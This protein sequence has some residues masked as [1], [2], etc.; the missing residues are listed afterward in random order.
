MLQLTNQM[1]EQ[2]VEKWDE[3]GFD[4]KS[5]SGDLAK[6]NLAILLEN[7]HNYLMEANPTVST[8]I[9]NFN[10]VLMPLVRRIF[11]HLIANDLVGVQPMT[12]PVGLAYAMRF[13]RADTGAE[14][15]FNTI[16]PTFTGTNAS[17]ASPYGQP[18][19]YNAADS[20]STYA[21]AA[22][23]VTTGTGVSTSAGE[24]MD[25]NYDG[26]NPGAY[27]N[28]PASSMARGKATVEQVMVSAK[29]RKMKV[30]YSLEAAQDLKNMH[31]VELEQELVNLLQYEVAAEI[32]REL[33][34]HIN[35]LAATYTTNYV[36]SAGDAG[37][38]TGEA[39][40]FR[41]LYTRMVRESAA[42]A[43]RTRR[44]AG[45]FIV[46]SDNV[47]TALDGLG[48][49]L[50]Q[51]IESGHMELN[52]GVAK[53]GSIGNR[54]NVYRDTFATTDY[55]TIGYKGP[56]AQNAGVIYCP[57]IPLMLSKT[58]EPGAFYPV[59]GVLTRYGIVDYLFGGA[60]FYGMVVPDF[61]GIFTSIAGSGSEFVGT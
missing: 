17:G 58:I 3:K 38:T 18:G 23:Q 16:D 30:D 48:Q 2:L 35:A 47:I 43:T 32:D 51:P 28:A 1:M 25:A 54:F 41:A 6:K 36:V 24:L 14:L 34:N 56:G 52:P 42:I 50:L 49:F 33:V 21:D 55:A 12:G 7:E 10:R 57:Y 8:D 26:T 39:G 45:N 20:Q 9:A 27:Q 29:T 15:G 40:K 53:V 4:L 60:D 22:S 37:S 19:A 46:A 5:L 61:S 31:G 13:R 44:G 11:P 59:I